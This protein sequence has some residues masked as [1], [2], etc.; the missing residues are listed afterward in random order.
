VSNVFSKTIFCKFH[1]NRTFRVGKPS[2]L[3]ILQK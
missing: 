3:A 1:Q 2:L